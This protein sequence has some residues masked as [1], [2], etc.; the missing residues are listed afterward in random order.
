MK[1]TGECNN[2]HQIV[3]L[4][5]LWL[6]P[7]CKVYYEIEEHD[8]APLDIWFMKKTIKN[9]KRKKVQMKKELEIL[10]KIEKNET[11]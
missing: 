2:G 4:D 3:E 1:V 5:G 9:L 7:I 8:L 10:E 11:A 6:C